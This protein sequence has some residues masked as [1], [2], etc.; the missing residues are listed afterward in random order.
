MRRRRVLRVVGALLAIATIARRALA[1]RVPRSPEAMARLVHELG[2]ARSYKVRI[3]AAAL[4]ARVKDP[5]AYQALARAA[6]ADGHPTVRAF[7]VRTLG[8]NP[9]GDV[10]SGQ[11]ARLAIGRAMADRDPGV[12]RQALLSMGELERR[13]SVG[14]PA[15][16]QS[17]VVAVGPMGDRT[18][19]APRALRDRMRAELQALLGRQGKIQLADTSAPGVTFV[20]DGTISKL[21]VDT[22]GADVEAVCEV[23]LVVSRPPRGIVTIASGE[24]IVQKPKRYFRPAMRERMETEALDHAV[25]SAHEN[26]SRFLAAQ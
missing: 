15:R 7:V 20:V 9:G 25:R 22:S 8:R 13:L 12:R 26:L 18:G 2:S 3:Q 14:A 24:A 6:S 11:Q 19:R 23:Q 16:R 21:S 4:L 1:A 10:V 17:T 5:R